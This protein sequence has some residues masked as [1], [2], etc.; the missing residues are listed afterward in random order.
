MGEL[1]AR[2]R[3]GASSTAAF[4]SALHFS[5]DAMCVWIAN[6]LLTNVFKLLVGRYR[7]DWLARCQPAA[8]APLQVAYGLPASANPAC[9]S[10]LPLSE[11]KDGHLSF[12]SGHA[13]TA[14]AWGV[15]GA[16]YCLWA[17]FWRPARRYAAAGQART[18]RER[19]AEDACSTLVFYWALWQPAWA[20]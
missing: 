5:L 10:G 7:P 17:A 8:P 13:S 16:A 19:A 1:A 20:W 11:I 9:A 3:L 4:A 12:P 18:W 2:R 15:Y 6:A 14:F